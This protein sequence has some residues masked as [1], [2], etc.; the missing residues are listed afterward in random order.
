MTTR[1]WL[2]ICAACALLGSL[3]TEWAH[4]WELVV[5]A[6]QAEHRTAPND[7]A[8]ESIPGA[9]PALP[10]PAKPAGSTRTRTT[11]LHV[12]QPA[13]NLPERRV[14]DVVCPAERVR[15]PPLDL[16][17][18]W[19]Q[20]QS[21]QT[22]PAVRGSEGATITG[23]DM[24]AT[25]LLNTMLRDKRLT[26]VGNPNGDIVATFHKGAGRWSVA[27]SAGYI[28]GEPWAAAGGSFSWH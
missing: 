20:L 9:K 21:G 17:I 26:I 22:Q 23:R 14:G 8:I 13:V 19:N 3:L 25:D 15:C 6:Y 27:G 28:D 16:R 24:P 7:V 4:S 10:A 5:P 2:L 12:E 18:D 1:A 11:E